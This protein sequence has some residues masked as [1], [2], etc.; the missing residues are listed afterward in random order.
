MSKIHLF[1]VQQRMKLAER[2]DRI[3]QTDRRFFERHP[4]RRH[5]VRPA[6]QAEYEQ[7][8]LLGGKPLAIPPG[9]RLFIAIRNISPGARLRVFFPAPEIRETDIS[10]AAAREVFETVAP[11]Q[12]WAAEAE[13]RKAAGQSSRGGVS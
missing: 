4:H 5:C 8:A 3:T 11:P 9:S 1:L 13:L 2:V 12:A 7:H 10:E 6:G